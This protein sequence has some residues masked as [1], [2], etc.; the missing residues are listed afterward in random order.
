M[1]FSNSADPQKEC[2]NLVSQYKTCMKGYG[3][4]I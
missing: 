3:F 4:N 1:L 2:Q